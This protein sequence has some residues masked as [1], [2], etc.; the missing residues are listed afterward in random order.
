M[1]NE[2]LDGPRDQT[3]RTKARRLSGEIPT[4]PSASVSLP[5]LDVMFWRLDQQIGLSSRSVAFDWARRAADLI[6][7]NGVFKFLTQGDRLVFV[8]PEIAYGDLELHA[9]V[10]ASIL[11]APVDVPGEDKVDIELVA[12]YL[13]VSRNQLLMVKR[14]RP[15][16]MLW[17]ESFRVYRLEQLHLGQSPEEDHFRWVELAEL[18]GRMLFV[19]RGCSVAFEVHDFADYPK[20]VEG[21]Y[22]KGDVAE[23]DDLV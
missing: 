12:R 10:W 5:H 16:N 1:L 7:D 6:H 4:Q 15:M 9:D 8:V 14:Y 3:R 19:A 18:D 17:T 13:V 22:F 23:F 2:A 20:A 21:V 11:N